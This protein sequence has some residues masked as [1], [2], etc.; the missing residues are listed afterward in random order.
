VQRISIRTGYS[1]DA[2]HKTGLDI[3]ALDIN[4]ERTHAVLAGKEIL[5][6]VRVQDAKIVD[7]TNLRAAVLNY[8]DSHA[9]SARGSASMT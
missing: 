6:T 7:E 2:S 3:S 9:A 1:Q 5:K 4:R 8:A